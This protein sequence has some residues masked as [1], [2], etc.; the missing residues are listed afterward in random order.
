MMSE[1]A[2]FRQLPHGVPFCTYTSHV[3][4]RSIERDGT[5]RRP[6]FL[7]SAA[8]L[9]QVAAWFLPAVNVFDIRPVGWEVFLATFSS[10]WPSKDA[11]YGTWYAPLLAGVTT[12]T[13]FFFILGSP[14]VVFRGSPSLRRNSARL[15]TAAFVVNAHWL[16]FGVLSLR[17]LRVGYFFWWFSFAILAIGLFDQAGRDNAAESTQRQ[18]AVLPR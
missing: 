18:P 3:K 14:W 12:L 8:W 15:A 5:M 11:S 17:E 1:M 13:T 16:I 7:I 2:M 4:N 6:H 9:L 10:V